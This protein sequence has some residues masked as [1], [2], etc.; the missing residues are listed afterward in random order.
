MD[1][2]SNL[3]KEVARL[4][5]QCSSINSL[6]SFVVKYWLFIVTMISYEPKRYQHAYVQPLKAASSGYHL[7]PA[8]VLAPKASAAEIQEYIQQSAYKFFTPNFI[9]LPKPRMKPTIRYR[10]NNCCSEISLENKLHSTFG[11]R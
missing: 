3:W 1:F 2:Q 9:H 7:K 11:K 6:Y 10:K 8:H 5:K 4:F